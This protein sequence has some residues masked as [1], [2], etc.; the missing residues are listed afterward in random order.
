LALI[1]LY[2]AALSPFLGARCRFH[3]TCSDYAREAVTRFGAARGG[4]MAAWR[5]ARCQPLCA[6]GIDP[7]P[8]TFRLAGCARKEP[9][10]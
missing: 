4:L 8:E 2:K 5:I 6:G 10:E 3:P 9:A 7:V 1:A